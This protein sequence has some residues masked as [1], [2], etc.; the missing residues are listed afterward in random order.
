MDNV[1]I[2]LIEHYPC[3]DITEAKARELYW[4]NNYQTKQN[5][6]QP[7]PPANILGGIKEW[8]A[9]YRKLNEEQ[10]KTKNITKKQ[11]EFCGNMVS[12]RNLSRHQQVHCT[13]STKLNNEKIAKTTEQTQKYREE[14]AEDI[15]EQKKKYESAKIACDLCGLEMRRD[16][17]KRH[18]KNYCSNRN[19][20][21]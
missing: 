10:I 12:S 17:I 20:S 4:K 14:H 5:N 19:K 3:K 2:V 16:S 9:E 11:C 18:Q 1:Q 8:G 21:D 13:K 15:K 7:I 6:P